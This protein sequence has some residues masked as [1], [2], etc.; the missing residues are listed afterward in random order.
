MVANAL[1]KFGHIFI[2]ARDNGH[3]GVSFEAAEL[4]NGNVGAFAN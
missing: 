1:H 3:R 4:L 2:A